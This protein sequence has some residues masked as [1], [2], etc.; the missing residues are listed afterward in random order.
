M[1][2]KPGVRGRW[3]QTAESSRCLC[4]GEKHAQTRTAHELGLGRNRRQGRKGCWGQR[5]GR[6]RAPGSGGAARLGGSAGRAEPGE[7]GGG[8]RSLAVRGPDSCGGDHSAQ[9]CSDPGLT[10]GHKSHLRG[11]DLLSARTAPAPAPPLLPWELPLVRSGPSSLVCR[12]N[13][14]K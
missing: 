11:R 2:P 7:A 14:E 8:Q 1:T 5:P 13:P 6:S 10:L 3:A 9:L 12:K 4:C